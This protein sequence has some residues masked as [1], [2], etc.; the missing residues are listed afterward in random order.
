MKT[1]YV[2]LSPQRVLIAGRLLG[3]AARRIPRL[4]NQAYFGRFAPLQEEDIPSPSLPGPNFVRVRNRLSAICGSDLHFVM[5]EGNLSIAPAALPGTTGRNYMGHEIVGDIIEVGPEVTKVKVGD[6][7][8]QHSGDDTCL[9]RGLQTPCRQCAIGNYNLCE[10]EAPRDLPHSV[11]GGWSEEWVTVEGRLYPLPDDITDEQAVLIEPAGSGVR[12]ALRHRP[13]PG[14]KVLVLGCG[15]Q[16]LMTLQSLRAV[17]PDCEITALARFDYQADM[18]RR[19][20]ARHIIM[21]GTDAYRQV[22]DLTGGRL[23]KGF[24][25]NRHIMGGF[26]AVYDCV[27]LPRTLRDALRWTRNRGTV[28]LVGVYLAPMHIDLTPVFYHEVNLIGV[29]AHGAE[30]WEG[31]RL[32]TFDLIVRWLREGKLNFDGFITHRFPLSQH[33]EALMAA[34]DQPRSRSIKV[35]FDMRDQAPEGR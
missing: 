5:A 24:M 2:D 34:I 16:G 31:E 27:G 28:V 14:D 1:L 20:G 21:L 7:V 35:V 10:W 11:G 13:S 33:R 22:A 23:Y 4:R 15:T 29:L 30:D 25:G 8:A 18:A 32:S 6:R 17:Q 19:L 26:D 12:A 9:A 3:P